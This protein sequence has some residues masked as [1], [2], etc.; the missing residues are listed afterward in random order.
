MLAKLGGCPRKWKWPMEPL[1]GKYVE[2][3]MGQYM[4]V[5][6]GNPL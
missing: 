1:N 6:V 2:G 4:N 3:Y 5:T